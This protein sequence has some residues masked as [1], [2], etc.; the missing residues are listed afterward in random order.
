MPL[1]LTLIFLISLI[2]CGG[3]PKALT[4]PDATEGGWK[5][6]LNEPLDASRKPEWLSRMGLK[7]ARS[8]KYSGNIDV[9]ADFYELGN[10]ASALECMQL[11]KRAPAESVLL[12][13]NLFIVLRSNH[14]NREMLMDFS[15]ALEKAL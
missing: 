2:S 4:I 15:R 7:E 11:W 14:P 9:E 1:V 8:V 3:A 5:Q 13:R 12:K 10:D 6:A